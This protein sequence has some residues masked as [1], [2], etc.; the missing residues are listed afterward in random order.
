MDPREQPAWRRA[1]TNTLHAAIVL[2]AS[3]EDELHKKTGLL[4]AD[5]E[6]LINLIAADEP[7]RMSDIAQRLIL[8]PGGTTKVIDR[9]EAK[10]YVKRLPQPGDRRVT[11]LEVTK[12]GKDIT[13]DARAVI[14]KQLKKVWG[15]HIN[16]EEASVVIAVTDRFINDHKHH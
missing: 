12:I 10:G 13:A 1:A 3:I 4:L 9:L 2:K 11:I 16:D 6:A 8:S 15:E 7:L 14:D 5:N